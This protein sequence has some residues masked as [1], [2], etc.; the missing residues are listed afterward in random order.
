[1]AARQSSPRTPHNDG[2]CI[3]ALC[4]AP[5]NRKGPDSLLSLVRDAGSDPFN[6]SLYIFRAKRAD[7]VKIVW[8]DDRVTQIL[9]AFVRARFGRRSERLGAVSIDDAQQAFVF[10]EIETGIAAIRAQVN[11]ALPIRTANVHRGRARASHRIWSAS[12]S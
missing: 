11:R 10:E 9:K 8:W 6:G 12:K 5:H 4:G 3:I 7:R 1:M 2:N